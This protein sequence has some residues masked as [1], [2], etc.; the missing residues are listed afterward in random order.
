MQYE[1]KK[2]SNNSNLKLSF[3]LDYLLDFYAIRIINKPL[4]AKFKELS[5]GVIISLIA[6]I[7]SLTGAFI[8]YLTH[9]AV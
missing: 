6:L 2:K 9:F 4:N 5:N 8:V 7:L 3:S 1:Y